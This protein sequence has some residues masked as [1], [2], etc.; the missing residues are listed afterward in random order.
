MNCLV[1]EDLT[2]VRESYELVLQRS[3]VIDD[4]EGFATGM[5][6]LERAQSKRFQ[7][8]CIDLDLPDI[9]GIQ[10]AEKLADTAPSMRQLAITSYEEPFVIFR[11]RRS[12]YFMGY[13]GKSEAS[14]DL[15]L[16]AIDTI[17]GN[18]AFY[19]PAIL[20]KIDENQDAI[21]LMYQQLTPR[22]FDYCAYIAAGLSDE[23]IADYLGLSA[24]TIKGHRSK[25]IKKLGIESSR[26]F[27]AAALRL[28]LL[29][30]SQLDQIYRDVRGEDPMDI[31]R[32]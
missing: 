19:S 3:P 29:R 28:G 20:A 27:T 15:L 9:D 14:S 4:V 21:R 1:V 24:Y 18:Q 8:A 30:P 5:A 6:A 31:F 25:L 13:I 32:S 26:E 22:D 12:P 11:V 16:T 2:M 7:L 23:E 10:L 17:V